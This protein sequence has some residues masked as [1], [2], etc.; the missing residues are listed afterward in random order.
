MNQL[1][2]LLI[3][4]FFFLFFFFSLP[5]S[6]FINHFVFYLY[7]FSFFLFPNSFIHVKNIFVL[8][9]RFVCFKFFMVL[10]LLRLTS[11]M[12]ETELVIFHFTSSLL[13]VFLLNLFLQFVY[14]LHFS[15]FPK[16]FPFL[17]RLFSDM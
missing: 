10:K 4:C 16:F 13:F 3:L 2:L 5:L 6:C 14:H 7:L 1:A 9:I 8:L 17:L 15:S 12:N 11:L